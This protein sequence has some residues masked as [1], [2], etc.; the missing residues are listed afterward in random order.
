MKILFSAEEAAEAVLPLL[1]DAEEEL[2]LEATLTPPPVSEVLQ[3]VF[4]MGL[5]A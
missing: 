3:M 5:L 1:E 2:P 4:F